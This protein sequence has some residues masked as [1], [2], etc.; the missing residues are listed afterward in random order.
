MSATPGVDEAARGRS[1]LLSADAGA[2]QSRRLRQVIVIVATL[3]SLFPV[4]FMTVSAFKTKSRV[5]GQQV[6]PAAQ[7][8]LDNFTTAF[9]GEKFFIRF[10]NSTDPDRR[11]R[12]SSR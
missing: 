5:P 7:P 2:G 8:I 11:R 10:A 1:R 9:A 3:L 6:G 12:W 4:Y